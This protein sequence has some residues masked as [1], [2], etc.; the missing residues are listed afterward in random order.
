MIVTPSPALLILSRPWSRQ[1]P[2]RGS[3][4]NPP[5]GDAPVVVPSG[6]DPASFCFLGPGGEKLP[7]PLFSNPQKKKKQPRVTRPTA[8]SP[9]PGGG[10]L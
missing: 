10:G 6:G 1:D 3:R 4:S 7:G 2:V 9:R 5:R 8:A